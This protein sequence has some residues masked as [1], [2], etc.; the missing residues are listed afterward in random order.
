VVEQVEQDN[1]AVVVVLVAS[2]QIQQYPLLLEL[3]T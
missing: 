3:L 2:E 1:E